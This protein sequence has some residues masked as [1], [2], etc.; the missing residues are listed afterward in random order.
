[1]RHDVL[2]EAYDS[3]GESVASLFAGKEEGFFVPAYQRKYTWEKQNVEQLFDD[4]VHGIREIVSPVG[5]RAATFL[6]TAIVT[7]MRHPRTT[8]RSGEQRALPTSVQLVIDGQ[9]RISTIG[10]LAIGLAEAMKEVLPE[11]PSG[12]PYGLLKKHSVKLLKDLKPL[13]AVRTDRDEERPYKPRIIREQDDRW[14]FGKG[15]EGSYQS[16]VARYVATYL[17]TES[18]KQALE[19]LDPTAGAR[20]HRNVRE[21]DVSLEGI[22]F[23]GGPESRFS[24]EFPLGE[25]VAAERVQRQ[26]LGGYRAEIREVLARSADSLEPGELSAVGAYRL[27][28]FAYYLLRRCGV[29]RLSAAEEEWGFDMFQSLNTTGTPLTALETLLPQVIRAEE[30]YSGAWPE[31]KSQVSMERVE[32]L[33]RVTKTNEQKNRRTNELLGTFA[34]CYEGKKLGNKFSGQSRWLKQTYRDFESMGFRREWLRCLAGVAEFYR[35]CWF[36]E[37]VGTDDRVEALNEHPEA[38]LVSMLV[39]YLREAGSK[40]P[41]PILARFYCAMRDGALP[42]GEFIEAT[43]ACAA[44]FT[45]W[46][47]AHST[48][49]L[50]GVFRQYFKGRRRSG[51][52]AKGASS[53][54][55]EGHAWAKNPGSPSTEVLKKYFRDVLAGEGISE[56]KAWIRETGQMLRY[57]E[58]K[59]VCRFVLFVSGN[60]RVADKEK[61]GMTLPG[62]L[63]ACPLLVLSEWDGDDLSTIEHVAPQ[64]RPRESN[65][66]ESIYAEGVVH[67]I[68]N[69]ILL[70][71]EVNQVA[72]NKDWATKFIYYSHVGLTDEGEVTRLRKEA[73][74]RGLVLSEK[75]TKI[76]R[77]A[78]HNCAIVPVLMVGE[79]G[80]W[81]RK[82]IARRSQHLR[83]IAWERLSAW[84]QP[85]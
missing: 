46:R 77:R 84:L 74:E 2:D 78:K 11:L 3:R 59:A 45:L 13:Y 16:P 44:F 43:K 23:A 67:D 65:W 72:D 15:G 61:L 60:D 30:R 10:L 25:E 55:V 54:Q 57:N 50:D 79:E 5:S 33:F 39:Q 28:L 12:G 66:D 83:N 71:T 18:S 9:Q 14:S 7:T 8:V 27:S 19:A 22:R 62:R 6:G 58:V 63:G 49:G 24:E 69:L 52:A 48:S 73:R 32:R 81:D 17:A 38:D 68:G 37:N 20:V 36:M 80:V 26:V 53:V 85:S 41:A 56:R 51:R 70:P 47:A 42:V 35:A 75:A 76:L 82:F 40:L 34:L 64:S 29:N 31:S 21:I 4:L 1:M